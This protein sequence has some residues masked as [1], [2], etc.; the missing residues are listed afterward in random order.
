MSTS[1]VFLPN[2]S[3]M[4]NGGRI[5][6]FTVW[7]VALVMSAAS[8]LA[9]TWVEPTLSTRTSAA[10]ARAVD[11]TSANTTIPVLAAR[12][13]SSLRVVMEIILHAA[14]VRFQVLRQSACRAAAGY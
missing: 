8:A 1:K 5:V 3:S 12:I 2:S 4:L 13:V 14:T 7:P 11:A 6:K 9:A 10:L